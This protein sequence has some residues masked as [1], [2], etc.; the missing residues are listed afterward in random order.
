MIAGV[1]F[2]PAC[3]GNAVP[4]WNRPRLT[5]VH[6][7]VCGER[8]RRAASDASN[9]GSSPRVRGT[10]PLASKSEQ[11]QRFIPAC[12]GNA[13]CGSRAPSALAGS[14]PR[15]RGTRNQHARRRHESRFIPACAGNAAHCGKSG[16]LSTVHPRV[17]GER[18][19]HVAVCSILSGSSP[20]VRGTP[21]TSIS[22]AGHC[23]F[24]PACAG[25]AILFAL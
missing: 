13:T 16:R 4:G 20:R 21:G 7:R 23:R 12:A 10:H 15:V 11:R 19:A 18:G 2:I 9:A 22:A 1:R 3:A 17:C 24:I 5:P 6:P 8:V 25:N 14:S